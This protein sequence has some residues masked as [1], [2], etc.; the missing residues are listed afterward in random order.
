MSS[1]SK[2][3]PGAPP[4]LLG[5][6]VDLLATVARSRLGA[7]LVFGGGAALA[8]VYLHHRLSED[9]DFFLEREVEPADLRPITRALTRQGI[10]VDQNVLGPRRSLV[11]SRNGREL[12]KVD[13]AYYPYAP[14]G[15]RPLWSRLRVESLIDM[16]VN[17]VQAALT[18]TQARDLVDLY[19]LL[20][21]GPERD[22]DRLLDLVRAKFDAGGDRLA[23]ASRLL[24]V[25]E[26]RELP[27]LLRPVTREALVAFFEDRA[28]QLV[29]R[30]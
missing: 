29:R 3:R 11:L 7:S 22:L 6:Q 28:R 20:Q 2:R 25:R 15:R 13:L 5:W 30:G 21:E 27:R 9:L 4:E 19:F 8:A 26:I 23:L 24:M 10:S 14:I 16:A 1:G 12:G 18:R 17:K